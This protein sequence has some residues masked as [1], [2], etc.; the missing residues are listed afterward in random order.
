MPSNGLEKSFQKTQR[1]KFAKG[2]NS[3]LGVRQISDEESPDMN[4][5]DFKGKG[6]IG[7]RQGYTQ[8]GAADATNNDGVVGMGA[9]HT[10]T[11]HQLLRFAK[12]GSTNVKLEHSTDGAAWTQVADTFAVLNIDGCQAAKNFYVGN[13]SDVMKHWDGAAWNTTTNGTKG[14][15]P[16]FYSQRLWVVDEVEPD[17]LNFSGQYSEQL[18][19]GGSLVNKLGDFSDATAGWISFKYGSGAE[20]TGLKVFKDSLYVFLRDSIYKISPA[21]AAN[22]FT[23]TQV[24]NS[25][26]CVSHRSI[27]QVEEDLFFAADDGVYA[28]GEVANYVSVRTTNK[29][30]RIQGVFDNMTAA[31]KSKLVGAYFNFKYHLYYSKSNGDNDSCVAFDVRYQGWVPWSNM[32]ASAATLYVSSTNDKQLYF[33]HPTTSA[34]YKM[35][36]GTTDDGAV[37][38]SYWTS[39]SFDEDLPDTLKVYFDHTFIFGLLNGTVGM[40]IIFDDNEIYTTESISQVRPLG[41]MGASPFG[42][43]PFGVYT[44]TITT[45]NDYRG[46]PLRLRASDKKF[47]VQYKITST[48]DWRLDNITTTYKGLGHYAFISNYQIN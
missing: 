43:K 44:N 19:T 23:I 7:N 29:S 16:T 10:S 47:A 25:V 14:Y 32:A 36:S 37:I 22:T 31:T 17:R 35:Y 2:W 1:D 20:I 28:L 27:T 46:V 41:G 45:I 42:R 15:W 12:N 39:K 33:G 26:G 30:A 21:T 40:R 6:G 24:T 9:L 5:C 11:I 8:I 13:G 34:V 3:F 38:N 4:N 18:L 48:G